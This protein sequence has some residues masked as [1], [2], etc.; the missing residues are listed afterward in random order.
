MVRRRGALAGAVLL[1]VVIA[2][3]AWRLSAAS[4][5][6]AAHSVRAERSPAQPGG[7]E[8]PETANHSV[9]AERGPAQPGGVEAPPTPPPADAPAPAAAVRPARP[10]VDVAG[11]ERARLAFG[12]RELGRIAPY[13]K[14][15]LDAAR[16]DMAFCFARGG[17]GEADAPADPTILTLYLEAREGAIDVVES[18]VDHRGAARPELIECCREVL[19][20][21]EISAFGAVPGQR[22]RFKY[23]LE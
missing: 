1:A 2:L 16:R 3:V 23:A 8:A 11:W 17:A 5:A 4:T 6:T 15:G 22:Y 21:Y 12:F 7:V 18:A 20:G 14:T 13:V 9:R 19:R 10:P